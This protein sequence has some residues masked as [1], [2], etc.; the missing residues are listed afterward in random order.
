MPVVVSIVAA[1][2]K[3]FV[4]LGGCEVVIASESLDESAES[5]FGHPLVGWTVGLGIETIFAHRRRNL[6]PV[7][8]FEVGE[9]FGGPAVAHVCCGSTGNGGV[10]VRSFCLRGSRFAVLIPNFKTRGFIG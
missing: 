9:V 7:E 1:Y 10:S 2:I 5:V 4:E 3:P 8:C 6:V